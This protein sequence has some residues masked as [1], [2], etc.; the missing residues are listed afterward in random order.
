M[1]TNGRPVGTE[2]LRVLLASSSPAT[3]PL[4]AAALAG[5]F[6]SIAIHQARTAVEL[7]AALTDGESSVVVLDSRWPDG[8]LAALHAI[9]TWRPDVPVVLMVDRGE[10]GLVREAVQAGLDG[11]SLRSG[12]G[13]PGLPFAV[14]LA[15]GGVRERQALKDAEARYRSLFDRVPVGLYRTTS[16]GRII[17]VNQA[18]VQMLG[19]PSREALLSANAVELYVNR[20]DRERWATLVVVTGTVLSFEVQLRRWTG[21]P[22]WGA[23]STRRVEDPTTGRVYYEGILEDITERKHAERALRESEE[24]FRTIVEQA[25][26]SIQVMSPEGWTVQVNRAWEQLWGVTA[27]DVR[28]Y[29]MLRDEQARTLGMMPYVERGFRGEVVS[30]PPVAYHTPESLKTGRKRWFQAQIYPLKNERGEIRNVIMMYEDI[31][32]RKWA[33]DD[34]Q[35]LSLELMSAQE[36]ERKRISQELHDELGQALTAIRINLAA[37]ERDMP[38][39]SGSR[40][41]ER[42]TETGELVDQML[43]HVRELSH[44]LRPTML[45]ELGL[46]PTLRWYANRFARRLGIGLDFEAV[47][48]EERPS[49]EVETAVYRILQEALTNVARY[50]QARHVK[51]HLAR[52]DGLLTLTIE[53][54]GVGFDVERS[55]RKRAGAGLFGMRERAALLGGTLV[56]QSAPGRGTRLSAEMPMTR[57]DAQGEP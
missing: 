11:F 37:M 48:L 22:I 44:D 33:T 6:S 9:K 28:H 54:D 36:A 41:V 4:V 42:L 52:R 35:R 43:E 46:V 27:A 18:F 39:E 45:D 3:S 23:L 16:D 21:E 29:N 56:M 26:V 47:N 53:D 5:E 30:M 55:L 34:L 8:S 57:K 50:A 40:L 2:T 38:H 49:P 25:P 13:L 32:E 31:T 1:H 7:Q 20:E 17:D 51:I 19:Y 24:R 15:L 14:W 10:D 12:D